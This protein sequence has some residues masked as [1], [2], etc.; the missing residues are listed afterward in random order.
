[1]TIIL[2]KL[3]VITMVLYFSL[4]MWVNSAQAS[5]ILNAQFQATQACEAFQSIRKKTNPGKIGLTPDTIYP[6]IA[7]NK[8]EATYYYLRI[9]GAEPSSRWVSVDCGILLGVEP[10]TGLPEDR[11]SDEF[12]GP[13]GSGGGVND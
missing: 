8:E 9:D 11:S 3:F 4:T 1:M 12:Y 6:V 7:K 2:K 10:T 5:I 13:H